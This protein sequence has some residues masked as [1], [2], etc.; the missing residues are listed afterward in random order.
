MSNIVLNLRNLLSRQP[1]VVVDPFRTLD[2][3]VA[4]AIRQIH[5][6][7]TQVFDG[8]GLFFVQ[9]ALVKRVERVHASEKETLGKIERLFIGLPAVVDYEILIR[10]IALKYAERRGVVASDP[11]DVEGAKARSLHPR[12]SVMRGPH[13]ARDGD[14]LQRPLVGMGRKVLGF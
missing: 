8:N 9:N 1:Y 4:C 14:G 2:R 5:D 7:L 3:R 12:N 6:D 13:A 10:W 11:R